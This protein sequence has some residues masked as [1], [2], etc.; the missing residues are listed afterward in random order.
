MMEN[1]EMVF[2]HS[3]LLDNYTYSYY[4]AKE[5]IFYVYCKHCK[6]FE[7]M[8][9]LTSSRYTHSY[10]HSFNSCSRYNDP[11]Y[12]NSFKVESSRYKAFEPVSIP[13]KK[14]EY[15]N[16]PFLRYYTP[17]KYQMLYNKFEQGYRNYKDYTKHIESTVKYFVCPTCNSRYEK[18]NVLNYETRQPNPY[19]FCYGAHVFKEQGKNG[20]L[21]KITFLYHT[22]GVF[23]HHV[24]TNRYRRKYV[25]NLT[26]GQSYMI[27]DK[28]ID[29]TNKRFNMPPVMNITYQGLDASCQRYFYKELLRKTY[30]A[31]YEEKTKQLGHEPDAYP[32]DPGSSFNF[33][34]LLFLNRFPNIN[35]NLI[36]KLKFYTDASGYTIYDKTY[37]KIKNNDDSWIETVLK[38][39]KLDNSNFNKKLI[40]Q[41]IS[42]L[43]IKIVSDHVK[44]KDNIRKLC[45]I[46]DTFCERDF[47]NPLFQDM[48]AKFG[49]TL[50]VNKITAERKFLYTDAIDMYR[51]VKNRN[52]VFP[53]N[54]TM[55]Q[56]H[57]GLSD[58]INK[59]KTANEVLTY[60]EEELKLQIVDDSDYYLLF[61]E[62]THALIDVGRQ[63]RI[64]VGGYNHAAL[65]KRCNII[66][67][68][69][70]QMNPLVCIELNDD[71][72]QVRQAKYFANGRL[73][74]K[75][76]NFVKE[77][78]AKNKL[79]IKTYDLDQP[80]VKEEAPCILHILVQREA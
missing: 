7:K 78:V 28:R 61:A 42:P 67:L 27:A 58:I 70:K 55:R 44:Q 24:I 46:E 25:F 9:V 73:P 56:I 10:S 49:E 8:G 68:R 29:G 18:H 34:T 39:Y 40:R 14:R 11:A 36:N 50:T 51:R 76:F 43:Q 65:A 59:I 63:M 22:Y 69:D 62:N 30:D 26:T 52:I 80:V 64:C 16:T 57:D 38:L 33:T 15:D 13:R 20:L 12:E 2:R 77:W 53:L 3:D 72:K 21:L 6:R 17:E 37:Y 5:K 48:I 60:S 66:V 75:E 45:L 4:N 74:E 47:N 31:M 23:H 71:C 79:K 32:L 41:N 54:G 19:E 35:L 1:V